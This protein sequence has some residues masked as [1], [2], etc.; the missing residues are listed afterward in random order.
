MAWRA[1]GKEEDPIRPTR[2]EHDV[3]E[4]WDGEELS[5][6]YNYPVY[7]FE[8]H[9]ARCSARTYL[10]DIKNVTLYGPFREGSSHEATPCPAL[11]AEVLAYL[12]RRY[13]VVERG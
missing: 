13:Q 3:D 1:T 9:G 4:I 5:E 10:D 7:Y 11:E 6:C 12:G 2:I 8:G